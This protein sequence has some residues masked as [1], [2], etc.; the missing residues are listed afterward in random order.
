MPATR[1]E[2]S[3]RFVLA[4]GDASYNDCS[5]TDAIR[6][7]TDNR[8]PGL[9]A[10]GQ[11]RAKLR[12]AL[13]FLNMSSKVH[14]EMTEKAEFPMLSMLSHFGLSRYQEVRT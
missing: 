1:V 12:G 6:D 11:A 5:S 2:A 13:G 10:W 8:Q 4:S 3:A 9:G 7:A 14:P